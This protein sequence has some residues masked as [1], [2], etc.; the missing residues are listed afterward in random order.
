MPGSV[1]KRWSWTGTR[2][3]CKSHEDS[4]CTNQD[5]AGSLARMPQSRQPLDLMS[6]LVSDL[7]GTVRCD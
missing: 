6:R 5:A 1:V 4:K 2:D 3:G 7:T